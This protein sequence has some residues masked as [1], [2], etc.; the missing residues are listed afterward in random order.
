VQNIKSRGLFGYG[1][2]YAKYQHLERSYPEDKGRKFLRN[3]ESNI[4]DHTVSDAGRS[5]IFLAVFHL[6]SGLYLKYK[7]TH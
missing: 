7:E 2:V 3:V 5:V 6:L 4:P 1:A